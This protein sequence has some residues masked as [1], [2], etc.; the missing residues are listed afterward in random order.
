MKKTFVGNW[1]QNMTLSEVESWLGEF[2]DLIKDFSTDLAVVIAPSHPYLGVIADFAKDYDWLFVGSQDISS[3]ENGTHTGEVGGNQVKDYADYCIVGH[4]ERGEELDLVL[5][6]I[7][8]AFANDL[9]PIIC[10]VEAEKLNDVKRDGA[11]LLWEDSGNISQDGVFKPKAVEDIATG[12]SEIKEKYGVAEGLIY[13]G[14]I[15]RQ[16]AN[17]I[18][19]IPE[20]DGGI[21]GG[22]SL[23]PQHFFELISAF[24]R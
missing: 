1:K 20:L 19:K 6:K 17:D 21:A 3:F 22:A 4:S 13:G 14:S 24:S 2:E 5:Q 9:I 11:V 23:D 12:V 18:G 7:D 10:F 8:Q 16:N 15:N